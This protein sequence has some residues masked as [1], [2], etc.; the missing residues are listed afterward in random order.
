[1]RFKSFQHVRTSCDHAATLHG[2]TRLEHASAA[3]G[4]GYQIHFR[5]SSLPVVVAFPLHF[6]FM[7]SKTLT[8]CHQHSSTFLQTG[9]VE[10]YEVLKS[11]EAGAEAGACEMASVSLAVTVSSTAASTASET[12]FR[13]L[14]RL[15]MLSSV[16]RRIQKGIKKASQGPPLALG[17]E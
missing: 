6:H 9:N 12:S 8:R 17:L 16:H 13:P 4:A 11:A 1:M 15:H 14:P 5:S 7:C 3:Q 2:E 10:R